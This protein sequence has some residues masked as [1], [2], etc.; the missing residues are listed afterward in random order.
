MEVVPLPD[1]EAVGGLAA[2]VIERQVRARPATVLGLAT[3]STPVPTYRSLVARSGIRWDDVTVVLL[4]EYVGLPAGHP[5]PTARR[6]GARSPTPSASRPTG[7]TVPTRRCCPTR[8]PPT[9][10]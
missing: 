9:S 1:A 3:G 8:D 5:S 6:S 7:C 10:G 2:D 4:D